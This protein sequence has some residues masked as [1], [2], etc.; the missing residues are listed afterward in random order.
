[1]SIFVKNK[2]KKLDTREMNKVKEVIVLVRQSLTR[3][4]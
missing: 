3:C 1:M 4:L 2:I